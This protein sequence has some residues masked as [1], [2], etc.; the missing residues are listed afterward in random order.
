MQKQNA[1]T[2]KLVQEEQ[3]LT[4]VQGQPWFQR[5]RVYLKFFGPGFLQSAMTLGGGTA[6]AC[7][8]AGSKYGYKL[9]WVQPL[10]MILGVIVLAVVGKLTMISG[11]RPYRFFWERLHPALAIFWAVSAMLACI[12]WHIP[13]YSLGVSSIKDMFIIWG[14]NQISTGTL[15]LFGFII[16]GFSSYLVFNYE[17]G[18]KGVRIFEIV[19]KILVWG[20][21]V[22]FALVAFV[23]GIQWGELIKGFTMFYIPF[24][25]PGGIT[26]VIGAL[27]AAVGINMVFLYPYTLLR[28][29][30]SKEYQG[31]AFFDLVG[32]M[33]VPFIFASTFMIIATANTVGTEAKSLM[34]ITAVL[35]DI[36]GL[37]LSGLILGIGLLAIS[38]TS[39]TT[40]MLA[41][42]FVGCEMFNQPTDGKWFKFFALVPAIGIVGSIY[43]LPFWAAVV[44]SSVAV[45]LMPLSLIGFLILLNSKNFLGENIPQGIKRWTWNIGLS[46]AILII[47]IAGLVRLVNKF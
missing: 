20:I 38:F 33:A 12:I 8:L 44:I 35:R 2:D 40:Q 24:D 25:D 1:F 16:L 22:V 17:K 14:A 36:I 9:L 28:K 7:L 19:M 23:T 43:A 29:R 3:M 27:G 13:Q 4:E 6:G 41:A 18:L 15:W 10:A 45:V 32:S 31:A 30:W 26:T 11:E 21:V 5:V 47:A 42:G 39:I 34:D 37:K 46:L